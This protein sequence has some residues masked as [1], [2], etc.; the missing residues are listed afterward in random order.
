MSDGRLK[1]QIASDGQLSEESRFYMESVASE[2]RVMTKEGLKAEPSRSRRA[3]RH[4]TS[5]A[6][7]AALDLD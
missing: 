1:K 3:A 2:C 7:E 6:Q 5:K 4:E